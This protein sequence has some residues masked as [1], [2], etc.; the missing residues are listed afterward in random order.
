MILYLKIQEGRHCFQYLFSVKKKKKRTVF[1]YLYPLQNRIT[2]SS[3]SCVF[4]QIFFLSPVYSVTKKKKTELAAWRHP[5]RIIQWM[6]SAYDSHVVKRNA[7]EVCASRRIHANVCQLL[8]NCWGSDDNSR[9]MF[10]LQNLVRSTRRIGRN[11]AR[12]SLDRRVVKVREEAFRR[13]QEITPFRNTVRSKFRCAKF[14]GWNFRMAKKFK[15]RAK[16][17]YIV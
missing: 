2:Y 9:W 10:L 7:R 3:H 5:R 1:S 8:A 15:S 13:C 6:H 17:D 12:F 11:K 4:L 14:P 16:L